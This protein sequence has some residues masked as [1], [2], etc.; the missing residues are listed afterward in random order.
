MPNT[1][2]LANWLGQ[3]GSD[4]V[5]QH[6][7]SEGMATQLV[8][9]DN[10]ALAT[11]LTAWQEL[12]AAGGVANNAGSTDA[13]AAGTQVLMTASSSSIAKVLGA[14]GDAFEVGVSAYPRV[15]SDAQA[16]ATVGGSCLVAFDKGEAA[17]NAAWS[18]M[19]FMTSAD[20]QVAFAAATGYVPSVK[21]AAE[22]A[23]WTDLV[24]AKPSFAAALE[25]IGAT[26]TTMSSVTVGPSADFY[27]AIQ[28]CVTD[29]LDQGMTVEETVDIMADELGGL[30][31]Q[32][33]QNNQ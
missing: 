5:D 6:N 8:C 33:V 32:Y 31:Q 20:V 1:P 10:G 24:A 19:Q 18:F 7:G 14:V 28:A 23:T 29:M 27:Y 26:P 30:L 17:R 21:S 9:L 2:T 22:T 3:L 16:G 4:L 25:Q 13:F 12:Y 11:F 15:N